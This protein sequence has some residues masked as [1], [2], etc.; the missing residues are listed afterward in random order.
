MFHQYTPYWPARTIGWGHW[1][2]PDFRSWEFHGEDIAPELAQEVNGVYSG[3][4][5]VDGGDLWCYYTG[6]VKHPGDHD[7]VHDGREAHEILLVAPGGADFAGERKVLLA[8]P[9]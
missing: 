5:I 7:Y 3:S 9:D 2:T 6:N 8:N 4:S 1:T